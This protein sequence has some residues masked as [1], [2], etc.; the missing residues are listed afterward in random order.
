MPLQIHID[1][2][3]NKES[4][5]EAI[6]KLQSLLD[7]DP[8]SIAKENSDSESDSDDYSDSSDEEEPKVEKKE[9]YKK[10]KDGT[11]ECFCGSIMDPRNFNRHKNTS[12]HRLWQT[13]K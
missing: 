11:I 1:I 4:I 8:K 13:K 5:E 3:F 9:E 12:K 2:D 7:V 10:N 6:K